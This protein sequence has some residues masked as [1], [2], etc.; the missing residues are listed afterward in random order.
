MNKRM[1]QERLKQLKDESRTI[2]FYEAPHKLPYTLKDMYNA[3]GN[4]RIA[5]AREL[6]KRYEEVIR[7]S[8]FEAMER[9]QNE[10]PKG[11]FVVIIE[12]QDQEILIEIERDKYT[13]I[14]IE[15][16]VNMHVEAGLSKKD[17]I[18]KVADD[19]GII[20]RDVYNVVM[21]K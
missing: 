2:I 1:R 14:S 21:K 13:N 8:L 3:W 10:T 15:E 7:C 12:G 16:H 18:K 5:L 11:E 19:R 20:K 17:A 6:T 9:Y 4:R